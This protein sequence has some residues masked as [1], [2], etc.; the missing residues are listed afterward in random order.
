MEGYKNQYSLDKR[1]QEAVNVKEKYPGLIPVIVEKQVGSNIPSID[2][3]KFLVPFDFTIAQ[4]LHIIRKRINISSEQALFIFVNNTLPPNSSQIYQ[5]YSKHKEEDQFL[6]IMYSG[7]N[8][9]G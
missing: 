2:K 9:F 8:T 5:V 1:R 3:R 6:Y 7:E 4:F